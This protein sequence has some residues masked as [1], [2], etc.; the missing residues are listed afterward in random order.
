MS[1]FF[2]DG[3][4]AVPISGELVLQNSGIVFEPENRET[5]P[6]LFHFSYKQI[7]SVEKLGKEYRL[8]L[9]DPQDLKNDLILTFTSEEK[10]EQIK[11]YR[12][13]SIN[14]GLSG[15]VSKFFLL[16]F[17]IQMLVAGILAFGVGFLILTKLDRMYVF[18]PE[19]ADKSLGE[20]ISKHFEENKKECKNVPLNL[21]IRKIRNA[22]VQKKN[23]D[24][25]SIIVLK[26]GEVNAFALPGGKIYILSGL[27]EESESA[28]EIAAIL[29]HEIAH[30]ENRHG[31][32]QLIRLLGISLVVKLSIGIGFDDIGNLETI[33]EIV[34]SLAILKYS[35]E[36]EEEADDKAFEILRRS[37]IGVNGFIHFFE[38]EEKKISKETYKTEKKKSQKDDG[39]NWDPAKIL[40][41]LS[42]HPDNQSRIQKAKEFSKG[43]KL[44]AKGIRIEKWETIR[45]GCS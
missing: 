34:N 4:S 19:S 30:V 31:I 14:N 37:G 32:R 15:L 2:Y 5:F 28:D 23:R 3:K 43:N 17:V 16:P 39:K 33:T 44:K 9:D 1:D 18:V 7:Q 27:I 40:D 36:F 10:A 29:A 8:Q 38:R 13:Q 6:D 41:W 45:V 11:N 20:L 21:S 24:Q 42:T 35:R 25:Y 26:S 12:K 22:L